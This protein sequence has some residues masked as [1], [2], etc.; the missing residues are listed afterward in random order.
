MK[1]HYLIGIV[2]VIL[3]VVAAVYIWKTK[4]PPR[5]ENSSPVRQ[6][7]TASEHEATKPQG[8][9]EEPQQ[10]P[11]EETPV[12]EIPADRQQMLGVET[13]EV[14][15][16]ELWKVIRTVGRIEYDERKLATVNA[17][18][19]GWIEKLHVD[20][21]GRQVKKGEPLA[22]IFSPELVATQQEFINAAKW[23]HQ[24]GD[25]KNDGI[26]A[27]LARDAN[28]LVEAS[29]QRLKFW[30]ISEEQIRK[31]EESGKPV[32]TLTLY[33]PVNGYVVQKMAL[34]GMRVMAG[35][36]LFDI[37]DLSSVWVVA[38]IY[39]NELPLVKL[40]QTAKI[41]LSYFPGREMTA[42]IDYVY[43]SLSADTR[44][45][46]VRF[47]VPNSGMQLKPQMFT[48]VEVTIPMGKKLAVPTEAVLDT[49]IRQIVYV[50]KGD[51]SF[52]PREI[53]TGI[54]VDQMQEVL[55]GLRQGEKIVSSAI[56]LIDSE[57]QI[58]G[59]KPLAGG[60]KH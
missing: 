52:E 18:F 9:R 33:S 6:T 47:T 48:N 34:Q 13:V 55:A 19:E 60:H 3:A 30:D 20:Y 37:A 12:V 22:E 27:M 35:E 40:G 24:S 51:G 29:R 4:S 5:G 21:T 23:A 58:K 17:K 53:R 44:T 54:K 8:V 28:A 26:N 10:E 15:V 45:A 41:S 16:R 57:A 11:A 56:F 36:K 46:K 14:T 42:V 25:A 1:K 7:Q 31:I 50:D 2:A 43:P 49:G 39:E 59:V 32:R 38:D